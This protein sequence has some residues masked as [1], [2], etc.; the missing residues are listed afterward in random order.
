MRFVSFFII[1]LVIIGAFSGAFFLGRSGYEAY[2]K[3]Q[4]IEEEIARLESEA[5][6][7]SV[8]N[9]ELEKKIVYF[10]TDSFTE[11][12]AKEK[13]N[14]KH[15]EE[16]VVLVKGRAVE[17]LEEDPKKQDPKITINGKEK[18]YIP[19]YKRWWTIFFSP[20]K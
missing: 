5:K 14:L 11:R 10:G 16:K 4:T 9:E 12:E 17:N 1:I 13:L 18:D 2:R 19:L 8:E 7:L 20:R 15:P 6:R 3:N